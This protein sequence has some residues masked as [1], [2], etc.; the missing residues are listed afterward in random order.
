MKNSPFLTS[1][2]RRTGYRVLSLFLAVLVALSTVYSLILP[3][4]AIGGDAASDDPA[5]FLEETTPAPQ[6]TEAPAADPTPEQTPEVQVTPTAEPGAEAG[7]SAGSSPAAGQESVR[8]PSVTFTKTVDGVRITIKAKSGAFPAGTQMK[9]SGEDDPGILSAAAGEAGGKAD[10]ILMFKIYFVDADGNQITPLK[11]LHYS[12]RYAPI[13]EADS[14]QL[15]RVDRVRVKKQIT[16]KSSTLRPLDEW[17]HADEVTF[18]SSKITYYGFA[19][20]AKTDA[21][22]ADEDAGEAAAPAQDEAPEAEALPADAPDGESVPEEDGGP[23]A[24][25]AEEEL[26]DEEPE[27]LGIEIDAEADY[28]EAEFEAE[29]EAEPEAESGTEPEAESGTA[30][31]AGGDGE[32][33]DAAGSAAESEA[34]PAGGTVVIDEN[35]REI[36]FSSEDVPE[37]EAEGAEEGE[38]LFFSDGEDSGEAL[39]DEAAEAEDPDGGEAEDEPS[40]E[41]GAGEGEAVP[42]EENAVPEHVESQMP[43]VTFYSRLGTLLVTAE[44]EE[45][46]FPRGTTMRVQWVTDEDILSTIENA[47]DG[48]VAEVR[49]VDITFLDAD[50]VE[51]EPAREIR[52]VIRDEMIRDARSIEVVHVDDENNASVV[53]QDNAGTAADEVA[54]SS[55]AFSVYGYV[56]IVLEDTVLT[57][58]GETYLVTTVC[59][60]EAGI[61]EGAV[62]RVAEMTEEETAAYLAQAAE[63]LGCQLEELTYA[64][65]LDISILNN[66]EEIQPLCGVDVKIELLDIKGQEDL[67]VL[68]F[69]DETE[70][71]DRSVDGGEVGFEASGFS[72]Y[73]IVGVEKITTTYLTADGEAY[74]ITVTYGP[75]AGVPE[76]AELEVSEILEAASAVDG[77]TEYENYLARTREALGL[78]TGVFS[79]ARFFDI[80]IVKNGK[81]V[82]IAAPVDVEIRLADM[83]S[84]AAAQVVHFADDEADGEVISDTDADGDTIRFEA[85]G[86]SAYAI[87]T[88]PGV[89]PIG[90]QKIDSVQALLEHADTGLYIGH[91]NGFYFTNTLTGNSS[92]MGITKTKP[93]SSYPGDSAVKY[94][95]EQD[96]E[97]SGKFRA[98]CYGS[99]GEKQYVY[100]GGN[101]SL[102]F[103]DGPGTAFSVSVN[104][105][106]QFKFNNGVW[107]WN[108][109]GGDNGARFCCYNN[110]NDTNNNLY[111]WYYDE[112]DSDPYGLDG[113]TYGLMNWTGGTTGKALMSEG[114]GSALD[115]KVLTVLST[116][117]N[118]SQLFAPSDSDITMWTFRWVGEDLYYL[119][120]VVDGNTRY[121]KLDSSGLSMVE[122]QADASQVRVVP[123]SG[124]HTGEIALTNGSAALTYSGSAE[125][126]FS[127]NGGVGSEWLY[128]VDLSELTSD[129]FLT[130]SARKV[131][132][133]D[134]AVTNG[135][136]VI[137][138][139]RAW[140]DAK[141]RYDFYAVDHDGTLVP[142]F[143]SGDS[144]EWVGRQFNTLLWNFVEYYWEGTNDPNFY[145]ELYNQYSEKYVAPQ[146]T[147][148]QILSDE[149]IGINLNGRRDGQ[150]YSPIMA[151]DEANYSYVGLKVENGRIVSC[152][153]SEAMD[154][155]FATVEDLNIDDILTPVTTID[156]T[157]YGITMRMIDIP[158]RE[159]MSAILGNDEGGA[160]TTL[161]QGLL[162]TSLDE[163]GY[164]QT[165]AGVSLSSMYAGAREVNHLFIES[166]Y[167]S[168]GYF[169][170]D[171]TENF[172]TL[173]D[174]NGNA[175]N[176]FTVYKELGTHDDKSSNTLKHGQFFPYND[177]TPG[178]FAS[179]NPRNLYMLSGG[180]GGTALLPDS[181]PR[182]NERLYL[183]KKPDYYFAMEL[184]ASFTQTP[185]GLDAWGHD[186]IFEFTGDD[187][188][189]LYVDGELV[190]DLG[191][192]HSAVPGSVNFRT[193][194]VNVNGRH[195]TL[196]ALFESNYRKRNPNASDDDVAAFLDNYFDEGS[197]VF[198]DYTNHTMRIFY[199]ERGAGASNLQMRF[200]LAA[201]KKDT[202]QLNKT[203]SGVDAS[204][205]IFAR[206]PYQILYKT[207]DG[208]EHYL[209]NALP[210]SAV[211]NTDY[212]FYQDS[213]NPVT[214]IKEIS[215]DG[216]SYND[217]F[218]LK[219][220]ETAD[221]S[222]PDSMV[223]YRIIECG[224]DTNVYESVTVNGDDAERIRGEGYPDD[225]SDFAIGYATTDERARVNYVNTVDPDALRNL[226]ITKTLFREDGV[227]PIPFEE[228]ST[229]FT[230]RLY[231]ASEFD[232]L[233]SANMQ[234]YHVR[235][236]EGNYCRWDAQTQM[237]VSLG[238]TVYG[239]L[240]DAEKAA[241]TFTTSIY[242]T[243]SRIPATYTVELR[244]LLAGTQ[245][246]VQERPTEIPDGYS[247]QKYIYNG[248]VSD[249]P[250]YTGIFDTIGFDADPEVEIC[251]LKGWGLRMNKV[252]SDAEYMSDRGP[253]YFAV[254]TRSGDDLAPVPDSVR[255]MDYEGS[256]LYWYWL[257]L[258]VTG[259]KFDDYVIREVTI[260]AEDPQ[261]D[262][263]GFVA[264]PGEVT[265]IP[266]GGSVFVTG[267]Q[268]GESESSVFGY[269]V[270]Y[271]QG[272][273]PDGSNIRTDTVTNTRPGLSL[274]KQDWNGG[275]LPGAV[276]SLEDAE[277]DLIG[278][279]TSG[280]DGA[281][282]V[283]FL[284]E[285]SAY[286]LTETRAPDA[287]HGLEAPLT[288]TLADGIYTVTGA[289]AAY[290]TLAQGEGQTPTL[291]I[292]NRPFTFRA[293]KQDSFS[294]EPLADAVFALH[295]QRTVD[296]V[297]A[298]DLNPMPGYEHLVTDADGLL[299]LVDN[300]LPAGTYELR[301]LTPPTGYQKLASYIDFTVS[302]T[303]A[304]ALLPGVP[305]DEAALTDE[306]T[307]DGTIA[308]TLT[309]FNSQHRTVS[310]WKTGQ[311]HTAITT[312]ASFSLYAAEDYDDASGRPRAGAEPVLTGTTGE[313][314]ILALGSLPSGSYRLVETDAPEGYNLFESAIVINVTPEGVNAM[315]G[316]GLAEVSVKGDPYWVEGQPDDTWQVRV[317]N[318]PG[319]VLPSSGGAGTGVLT[320]LGAALTLGALALLL[321]R[322]K[323]RSA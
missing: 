136:R 220:G 182:K 62:L 152:P 121:L 225:R 124:I 163:N 123:G 64:K 9:I 149:P 314:G 263:D 125:G 117:D 11:K 4:I 322:R 214:Y 247:F 71:L 242:G 301:E 21:P 176:T 237:F 153:S 10:E 127:V 288:I 84:A 49:A 79:Y 160:G 255:R 99:N 155:Y 183:F 22:A 96:P 159:E 158:T 61:P 206:F 201:V 28:A 165:L 169:R 23:A 222:F 205:Q 299:P 224:V 36:F 317:W 16:Y 230:F 89:I 60:P 234:P 246:R 27:E 243:I 35:G 42:V 145:Y 276:F 129:Y 58:D 323:K 39:S 277:G 119:T 291:T 318:N 195:T 90:W 188:F 157:Q 142:V 198:R 302:Q 207:E 55:G 115:A 68:H 59:P 138:Y 74:V 316:I 202:V 193:G 248:T 140:N 86:F 41:D 98:Y 290:Y 212:V 187:D 102:S 196:R 143:E 105:S 56:S 37:D 249:A 268:K 239:E 167:H 298:F 186:I 103:T 250:A 294:L 146:V 203:L 44:A 30:S 309:V 26:H 189:W 112:I 295:R 293:L 144:I 320:A 120:A 284:R 67:Q 232:T 272:Q 229:A 18:E 122:A 111:L 236:A 75:E 226:S 13:S 77:A 52:V 304:V 251:N 219:P 256:S 114:T 162:A 1:G 92:R 150:Y 253:A 166:S 8:M 303:G 292:R 258:P 14:V 279:F 154:F 80:S 228:D 223:S 151:W 2:L 45:D 46:T 181:D 192:I 297:T 130:Y 287:F 305:S 262:E 267:T 34:A 38:S 161:H 97:D 199:M 148:G 87:V 178:L 12:F 216:I 5:I 194:Q 321:L 17:T 210:S 307:G 179:V 170:Y 264:E 85:E 70:V 69:G 126:G 72:F 274:I 82:A 40:G 65:L 91:P 7:T 173:L 191:G 180:S 128:L 231:L 43:A 63:A 66:G 164:P 218:F 235:D 265:P 50:G 271:E 73:L 240:T 100:N 57:S 209:T 215:I 281:V 289:D 252:W 116:A 53:A 174:D 78:D 260:T 296:G 113:Q 185:N 109:Q 3:V 93:A 280:S 273:I 137:V 133:S 204:E 20:F 319:A 300:T 312:G 245:F 184:E 270:S 197:T 95:F 208:T 48:E 104:G 285:G 177:L 101:N 306:L 211:Q 19:V 213:V 24:D 6:P 168:S 233:D 190:I 278:S 308:Y 33:E 269:T 25:E 315:Q 227:T 110:A 29:S 47:V 221:I 131:S 259:V 31:E 132:V 261:T 283:A 88:G 106:G 200:N 171:S 254:F 32:G 172:A 81:K 147:D 76:G 310:V 135:S 275:A 108:M 15:L 257:T 141:K 94:F 238:K 51:I 107:Y 266:E 156:H 54:F 134:E 286:T 217:V 313:N 83:E 282:T 139:T 241:A 175:G 118:S 311:D 244:Q